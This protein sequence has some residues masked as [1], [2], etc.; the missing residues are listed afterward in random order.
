MDNTNSFDMEKYAEQMDA[1]YADRGSDKLGYQDFK[2]QY[3]EAVEKGFQEKGT[4]EVEIESRI[5]DKINEKYDALTVKPVGSDVG[6]NI[7]ITDAYEAYVNEN[8]PIGNIVD[9][10]VARTAAALENAPAISDRVDDFK[11]YDAMK[12]RLV[13]EVISTST[14]AEFLETVPHKE[15]EDMAVVYRFDVKVSSGRL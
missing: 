1:K 5:V 8:V 11:N 12:D 10:A 4:A 14:N 15:I 3:K 7:S 2:D 9:A 13:M 6:V